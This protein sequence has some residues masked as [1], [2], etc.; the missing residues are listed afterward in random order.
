LEALLDMC[1]TGAFCVQLALVAAN[2][3]LGRARRP[4]DPLAGYSAERAPRDGLASRQRRFGS[5]RGGPPRG[6]ATRSVWV[7]RAPRA[8]R[9]PS[10]LC[11]ARPRPTAVWDRAPCSTRPRPRGAPRRADSLWATTAGLGVLHSRSQPPAAPCS[12]HGAEP[13]GRER[14]RRASASRRQA[15]QAVRR[16]GRAGGGIRGG[17]ACAAPARRQRL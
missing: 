3:I 11:Q 5:R 9:G 12:N 7:V 8:P 2:T 13:T 6:G 16:R 14:E 10:T 1:A 17:G 15:A 4:G